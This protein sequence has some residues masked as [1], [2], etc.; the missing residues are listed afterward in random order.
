ML[1]VT[2]LRVARGDRIVQA[3][4]SFELAA[5]QILHLHG[6]NGAG[7]TTILEVLAGLRLPVGGRVEA[8]EPSQIHWIGHQPGFNLGLNALE[9]L[10]FW[11]GLQGVSVDAI[12]PALQELGVYKLRYRPLRQ[13]SAGQRRRVALARLQLD[14]RPLWLLD[15]PLAALDQAGIEQLQ[16]MLASHTATGGAVVLSSHQGLSPELNGLRVME[17][18]PC[19]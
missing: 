6:P 8:P 10:A 19:R 18:Q 7:K 12:G 3:K 16:Q 9:N 5:S 1:R 17:L 15:E 2:D 13:L 4:L 11:C 14:Q